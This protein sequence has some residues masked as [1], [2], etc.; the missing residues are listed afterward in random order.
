MFLCL[1]RYLERLQ[2]AGLTYFWKNNVITRV[3]HFRK[4]PI[5]SKKH[6][7]VKKFRIQTYPKNSQVWGPGEVKKRP[8][9]NFPEILGQTLSCC[10]S[11]S[12]LFISVKEHILSCTKDKLHSISVLSHRKAGHPGISHEKVHGHNDYPGVTS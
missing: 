4:N 8:L 1:L 10:F 7:P 12:G 5:K 9:Y 6:S 3:L 11:L 2:T